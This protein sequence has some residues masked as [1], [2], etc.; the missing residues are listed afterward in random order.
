MSAPHP[1]ILEFFAT[2]DAVAVLEASLAAAKGPERLPAML[3]LAWQMRQ[4]DTRRALALADEAQTSLDTDPCMP[5]RLADETA[6]CR[7]VARLMLIRGE[8]KFLA[9]EL[10]ACAI[11]G[12]K[13][14]LDFAACR[15]AIGCADAHWLQ[16]SVAVGQGDT[17]LADAELRAVAAVAQSADPVRVTMAH[18]AL[19]ARDAHHDVAAA[20][21]EWSAQLAAG[22]VDPHPAAASWAHGFFATLAS[23]SSEHVESIRHH[24]TS[25]AQALATGQIRRAVI[26]ATN[27][28]VEFNNLNDHHAA[29]EW[30]QR[31]LDLA[32]PHAWP[33]TMGV[34]L[35]QTA[36]TLRELQRFD[37][38]RELLQEAMV[39]MAPQAASRNYAVALRYLGEVELK[40]K[41]Y[42][43]A[44]ANCQ[45][46]EQRAEALK[47][48]D[49]LCNALRG[50]AQALLELDQPQ[51]A[52]AKAHAALVAAQSHAVHQ[53]D[54][55]RVL[56]DIHAR[57]ALPPPPGM[58]AASVPLHYLQQALAVAAT[59]ENY[60]V[61][62]DLLEAVAQA[63]ADAGDTAKAFALAKQAIAAR[64]ITHSQ[65]ASNRAVAIRVTHETQRARAEELHQRQLAEAHA[66]RADL[67]EQAN[68]AYHAVLENAQ[69]AIV[70]TDSQGR[71]HNW[72]QQAVL[73]FGWTLDEALGKD[74]LTMLF[75]AR[76]RDEVG[77]TMARQQT[78]QKNTPR[79]ETMATRR[80][81]SEFPI[82]L[83]VTSMRVR[84][85]FECSFFVRDITQRVQA[86][87]EIAESLARQR[88][89][90]D[91]KSR[92]V[93]M[94]SHE[95][96]T[97]LATILS[98][99]DLLKL[100]GAR[101]ADAERESCF[102]FISDSV[103]RMK[104]MLED[105]LL[106]GVTEAGVSQFKPSAHALGPLCESIVEEVQ[107][108]FA[109]P[110]ATAAHAIALG[111]AEPLC[112]VD[113]DERWFRHIFGNLLSNA[114]KYSP[115]GGVVRFEVTV[116]AEEAEFRVVDHGIG[117]PQ[118]D[119][120]RLFEPFFRASNIGKIT[121]TGLGLS[122]V[123]RAVELH[124]GRI[125]VASELGRGTT[126]TVVLPLRQSLLIQ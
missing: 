37:A 56:A 40:R 126:F 52:L 50:Q 93:S 88:E 85:Q 17:A 58:A 111:I 97:P 30:M 102:A 76:F 108:G 41:Q 77:A 34:A 47:T 106:I 107:R 110:S 18:A 12:A 19:A 64:E 78:A 68:E 112:L 109:D 89:L 75:P 101:M 80:D 44:L 4:R 91:L 66:G 125:S 26:A 49:L 35:L 43:D 99:S 46:L 84:D 114:I 113:L 118:Q 9:G 36:G 5:A 103:H 94:A 115:E 31:G 95:F 121:G 65:E 87:L 122:I 6:R 98:S 63:H 86:G 25:Y 59:I 82:E 92:F 100:Y 39:L 69:D 61:P 13:A 2:D 124:G 123:Q 42:A 73:S 117:L 1:P 79:L 53:I 116:H 10:D 8:A 22:I 70:L 16:F 67:L 27:L 29:L 45:L 54:A 11:L 23:Q 7:C 120:P 24:G 33:G 60:T 104:N 62:G 55:L 81:G 83:S 74:I 119:I 28:G 72:N 96:R 90:A 3:A 20:R 71:I 21:Q 105:V 51:A 38:A 32:R 48:A 15:D 14:L 57:H